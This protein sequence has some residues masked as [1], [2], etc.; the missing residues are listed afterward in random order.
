MLQ[1]KNAEVKK[2]EISQYKKDAQKAEKDAQKAEA[3]AKKKEAV[4][5]KAETEAQSK[6][7]V[8]AD[9]EKVAADAEAAQQAIADELQKG[10]DDVVNYQKNF[11]DKVA[12][13][14]A[15]SKDDTLGIVKKNKAANE[16]QQL[17]A[18]KDD[19]PLQK[20]KI[21]NEALKKKQAPLLQ[22]A[23]NA[24]AEAQKVREPFLKA[25]QAA[26]ADRAKATEGNK[27]SY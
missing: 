20:I 16:L 6:E 21:T 25:K 13:L 12:K 17:L 24:R 26:E 4:A 18:G 27:S 8:F 1:K 2:A 14:T 3:E 22:A 5:K 10:I 15:M 9:K 7:S 23:Q 11:D 19:T